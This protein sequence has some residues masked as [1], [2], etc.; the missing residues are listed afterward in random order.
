METTAPSRWHDGHQDRRYD[1]T[2]PGGVSAF[3]SQ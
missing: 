3:I 2:D 1:W